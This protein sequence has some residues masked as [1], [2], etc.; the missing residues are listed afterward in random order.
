MSGASR[1]GWRSSQKNWG[2]SFTHP[3]TGDEHPGR[4][5]SVVYRNSGALTRN[6]G[7]LPVTVAALLTA[8]SI[9]GRPLICELIARDSGENEAAVSSFFRAYVGRVIGPIL[10]MYLL[11][12]LAVE[13]HQQNSTILFDQKGRPKKR[14]L[15]DFGDARSFVPMLKERGTISSLSFGRGSYQQCLTTIS[16]SCAHS[17]STRAL[18]ATFM[19]SH[20]A[21]TN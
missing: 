4:F 18:S 6:D 17:S 15:H 10:T 16:V 9:D 2:Q 1:T 19:R 8:S 11:Y 20:Y 13:A 14:L 5:L 21:S 3:V 12:G 7:L